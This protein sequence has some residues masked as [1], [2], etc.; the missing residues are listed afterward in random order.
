MPPLPTWTLPL[1]SKTTPMVVVPLAKL[2]A[3]VPAL[4]KAVLP[5]SVIIELATSSLKVA[6]AELTMVPPPTVGASGSYPD[7]YS[8]SPN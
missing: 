1:L 6:P 4:S 8:H 5:V 7:R 2:V 3:N